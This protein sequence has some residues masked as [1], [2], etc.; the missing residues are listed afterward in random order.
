MQM[1]ELPLQRLSGDVEDTL[2]GD[3]TGMMLQ[4]LSRDVA[5]YIILGLYRDHVPY[6]LLGSSEL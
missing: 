1:I 6:S 4:R 5:N 2:Y 3:Y